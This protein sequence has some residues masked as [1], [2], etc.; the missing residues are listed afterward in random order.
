VV[1]ASVSDSSARRAENQ[2]AAVELVATAVPKF[3]GFVHNLI[4]S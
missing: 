4:K 2:R 3:S 1:K